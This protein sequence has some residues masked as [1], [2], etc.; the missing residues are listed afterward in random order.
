MNL[1]FF[2]RY[3]QFS[4]RIGSTADVIECRLLQS[5]DESV[6]VEFSTNGVTWRTLHVLDALMLHGDPEHVILELPDVARSEVTQFRWRQVCGHCASH[7]QWA[8]DSVV[9]AA[10]ATRMT[11]F[12]DDFGHLQSDV[13]FMTLNAVSKVTCESHGKAMEF[14]KNP[15]NIFYE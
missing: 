13:W 15:G 8:L 7:A 5:R 6:F 4:V 3:L 9:I 2:S 11:S 10:N 1:S 12:Y 14:S